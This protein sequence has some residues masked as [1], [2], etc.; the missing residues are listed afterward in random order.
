M[1]ATMVAIPNM[2]GKSHGFAQ[3]YHRKAGTSMGPTPRAMG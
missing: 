3:E 2:A 1:P